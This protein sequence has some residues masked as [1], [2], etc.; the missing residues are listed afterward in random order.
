VEESIEF[1]VTECGVQPDQAHWQCKTNHVLIT[2]R[3]LGIPFATATGDFLH[4]ESVLAIFDSGVLRQCEHSLRDLKTQ[5]DE[6]NRAGLLHNDPVPTNII[7]AL[8][9]GRTLVAR[10]VD[11]ELAQ[12]LSE[13]SPDYVSSSVRE[14]YAERNVPFNA[15]TG[16]HLKNLDQH[17]MEQAIEALDRIR[18][19]VEEY[20]SER[21]GTNWLSFSFSFVGGITINFSDAMRSSPGPAVVS[22]KR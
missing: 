22:L 19:R 9:E 8:G 5:L 10:L 4:Y 13:Q 3:I 21:R 12:D 11:F 20:E 6:A 14:L 16:K 7:F 1:L 18:K 17:L 2:E 15:Q